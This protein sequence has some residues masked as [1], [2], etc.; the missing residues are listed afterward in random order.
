[1]NKIVILVTGY[2]PPTV[3]DEDEART[4][5]VQTFDY[6]VQNHPGADVDLVAGFTNVGVMVPAYEEGK[7]RGWHLVGYACK[8]AENYEK[9]PVDEEHIIGAN[10]GEEST[11]F[12]QHAT[13]SG[14]PFYMINVAGGKQSAMETERIRE[15]GGTVIEIP[16]ERR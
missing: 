8:K 12:V 7:K 1:M 15:A 6:I 2:C 3:V 16:L 9:Y 5:I 14:C 4:R 11:D 13:L 10:W